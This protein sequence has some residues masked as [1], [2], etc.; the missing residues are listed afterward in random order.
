MN[1]FLIGLAVYLVWL[2]LGMWYFAHNLGNKGRRKEPW[3]G[4][5]AMLPVWPF[6]AL[7]GLITIL[8]RK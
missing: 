3:Y 7:M 6:A 8:T 2:G 5:V 4:G 1:I